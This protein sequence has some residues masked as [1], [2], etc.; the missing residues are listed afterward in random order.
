MHISLSYLRV[1]CWLRWAFGPFSGQVHRLTSPKVRTFHVFP[2]VRTKRKSAPFRVGYFRSCGPIHPITGR[3]SLFPTSCTLCSI[4]LP[5]GWDTTCVG[6]IGLTQLSI[7]KNVDWSGW[8]L[9]PGGGIGRRRPQLY[10][11]VL[12]TYRFGHGLSA[13]LAISASRDFTMTLHCRSALPSFP[14]PLP[15]RGWQ[16][17]EHCPQN[18]RPWITRWPV[19][20]GTPGHH[21]AQIGTPFHFR[22]FSTNLIRS[23]KCTLILLLVESQLKQ[24]AC[25]WQL[26]LS[27]PS[28][29]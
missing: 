14:S 28:A 2:T 1:H 21:R 9:C 13:S 19:W 26:T 8:S 3:P 17:S 12:P 10:E 16:Q 18:F 23:N 5:Y 6:S 4:S 27:P 24:T 11:A 25:E 15:R 29:P 22:Y 20:V 7:E